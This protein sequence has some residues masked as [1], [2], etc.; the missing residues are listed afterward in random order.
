MQ[1][2]LSIDYFSQNKF[3]DK[4]MSLSNPCKTMPNYDYRLEGHKVVDRSSWVASLT[5]L[6]GMMNGGSGPQ[7]FEACPISNKIELYSTGKA[8]WVSHI[9]MRLVQTLCILDNF[10]ISRNGV[11]LTSN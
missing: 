4:N 6:N 3:F 9:F 8:S 11:S 5:S 7:Q 1:Y 2:L 10:N